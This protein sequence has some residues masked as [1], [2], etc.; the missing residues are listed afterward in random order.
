MERRLNKTL[1]HITQEDLAGRANT[2]IETIHPDRN[3]GAFYGCRCVLWLDNETH[4]P[5]GAETYDWPRPGVAE[6]SDLLEW[7]RYFDLRCNLGLG[8]GAFPR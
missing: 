6:R 3:G 2:R 4:L 5:T 1:V 8:E 7:Y